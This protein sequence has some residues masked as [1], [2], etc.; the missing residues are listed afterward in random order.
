MY[1]YIIELA[2]FTI[3]IQLTK[4][5]KIRRNGKTKHT[6]FK[7]LFT[8]NYFFVLFCRVFSFYT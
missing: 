2:K 6:G 1:L 7:N 8:E 4:L 3:S 5:N